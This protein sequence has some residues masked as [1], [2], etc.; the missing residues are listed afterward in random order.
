MFFTDKKVVALDIGTS[1]IKLA[2]LDFSRRI[3]TLKKFAVLPLSPGLVSGGEIVE[4][5]AVAQAIESLVKSVK[6]KRKYVSTGMWGTSVIVKKISMPKMEEKLVAEQIKWEAEQ[7]IPFDVNEISLEYHIL[8]TRSA[9]MESM[10]VLLVA[11]KQEFLFRILEAVEGAGLKCGVVDVSGFALANCFE[12]NYGTVDGTIALLNIGAGVTNFVVVERGEVIFCRD[13]AVGGYNYT[14]DIHKS[15]GVSLVEAEALKIS[16]SLGQEV[17][18][19][20]NRIIANTNEQVVDEIR[21]SFEFFGAT[22][23]S[24]SPQRVVVS[25]G[26]IFIPGLVDQMTKAIGLSYELLDPFT[27][28]GYDSKVFSAEYISQIKAISPVVLGLAMRKFG[29]S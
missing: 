2:E 29:D 9:N 22:S 17:P 15:M 6:S 16:A 23:N 14:S 10:E 24:A 26:S 11:A 27:R 28:L 13:V 18:D 3:P 12:A 20:V 8:E 19:E 21:N 25:G 5:T 4:P 7:Y 1:S